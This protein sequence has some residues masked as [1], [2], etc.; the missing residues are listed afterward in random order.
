MTYENKDKIMHKDS[1]Y[2]FLEQTKS[3]CK[4]YKIKAENLNG[5]LFK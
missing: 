2:P 1:Q 3:G 4:K 5:N